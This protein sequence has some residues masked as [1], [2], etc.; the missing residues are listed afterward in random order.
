MSQAPVLIG[1][2]SAEPDHT[3][4]LTIPDGLK[5]KPTLAVPEPLDAPDGPAPLDEAAAALIARCE[6]E[7]T[8]NPP[9]TRAAR[10][11]YEIARLHEHPLNDARTASLHYQQAFDRVPDHTPTIQGL[12]R[13]LIARRAVKQALPL[14][15]AE[16]RLTSDP[17]AK[18][19]LWLAKG[20]VLED[21]LGLRSDALT[22]YRAGLD[23]DPSDPALLEA[24]EQAEL[25]SDDWADLSQTYEKQANV[26]EGDPP[27][28]SALLIRRAQLLESKLQ[29]AEGAVAL[30][31][32]ALELAPSASDALEALKRL[33]Y[34]KGRFRDLVGALE[35]EAARTDSASV[36]TTALYTIARVQAEKLGNRPDAIAALERAIEGAPFDRL[37]LSELAQLRDASRDY[38]GLSEV[39]AQL[40]EALSEDEEQAG[41]FHRIGQIHDEHLADPGAAQ[42]WFE[43]ALRIDPCYVP[44]LQ[45]LGNLYAAAGAHEALLAMHLAEAE[46]S[47]DPS[48]RAAAHA[49][50]A[51][52]YETKLGHID[53]AI[54]HHARALSAVPIYAPSFKALTRLFAAQGRHGE[55]IELYERAVERAESERAISYLLK[56]GALYEDQLRDPVQAIHAYRRVIERDMRHL[57]A[58]HALSRVTEAAGRFGELVEALVMEAELSTDK[59]HKVALLHRAGEVLDQ[60]INDREGAVALLKRVI[61]ID[62]RY[63]PA[64]TSLGR[65]YYRAGR[66]EDLLAMYQAELAVLGEDPRAVSLVLKMAELSEQRLGR[67]GEATELYR[68]AVLLDPSST[69]A[70]HAYTRKLRELGKWEDLL[71]L[72]AKEAKGAATPRERASCFFQMGEVLEYRLSRLDAALD[73]YEK[74]LGEAPSHRPAREAQIRLRSLRGDH[75]RL[76]DELLRE[77]STT[78]ET[79]LRV[80]LF[81]RAGEILRDQLRDLR[82]AIGCFEQVRDAQPTHLGTLIALD[83]LYRKTGQW[84][85][86]SSVLAAEAR[87]FGDVDTRAAALRELVRVASRGEPDRAALRDAYEAILDLVPNDLDALSGLEALALSMSDTALLLRV[88]ERFAQMAH[89]RAVRAAHLTR[90]GELLEAEEPQRAVEAYRAAL[91]VDPENLASTRGLSRLSERIDSPEVLAE[92]ARRESEVLHDR[93]TSSRL[94]VRAALARRAIRGE[95]R[96]V[97]ADLERALELDPDSE[98]AAY[99]LSETLLEVG[100]AQRLSDLLARAAGTASRARGAALWREVARLHA[101]ALNNV[102][103]AI[104]ALNRALRHAPDDVVLLWELANLFRRDG[105]WNEAANLLA[106]VVQISKA[107]GVLRD[108]HIELAAIH[109]E[110][111][112]DAESALTH[113]QQAL[114]LEP[115]NPAALERY[116]DV[117]SREKKHAEAATVAQRLVDVSRMPGARVSALL[118][119]ARIEQ[120]R[121]DRAGVSRALSEA[122]AIDGPSGGAGAAFRGAIGTETTYAD[123]AA[124]LRKHIQGLRGNIGAP[125][126]VYL[127]LAKVQAMELSSPAEGLA[128]LRE[129]L[130]KGPNNLNLRI[131]HARQLRAVGALEETA[132]EL[133]LLLVLDVERTQTWQDLAE[134]FAVMGRPDAEWRVSQALSLLG[135]IE[136]ERGQPQLAHVRAAAFAGSVLNELSYDLPP[137]DA[138]GELLVQLGEGLSK[139][140]PADLEG[141]G[142]SSRDKLTPRSGHPFRNLAERI[143]EIV[144]AGEFDLYVHRARNRGIGVELGDT[145]SLLFPGWLLEAPE[146]HQVFALAR[147]L[148][149]VARSCHAILKLTPREL[150][151]VLAA[152]ARTMVA[153]FGRGLTSEDLL[154]DQGRRIYKALSRRARKAAEEVVQRYVTTA[155]IEFVSWCDGRDRLA[156]RAAALLCDDLAAAVEGVLRSRSDAQP[157]NITIDLG[158]DSVRDLMRF[159]VSEPALRARTRAGIG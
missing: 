38:R 157:R 86:L 60:Q 65:I 34:A 35:I 48:R 113:L 52:L 75:A 16:A 7:L 151:V 97:A 32:T 114:K 118:H 101:D 92:A 102:A 29:D 66:W 96:Q 104:S 69:T 81:M 13:T 67:H 21:G 64:L 155:P 124:A 50:V 94:W 37:L 142:V 156:T 77:A 146:S 83:A 82:R 25:A 58:I 33:Y 80:S 145:P 120:R 74:A 24:M 143:A 31:E 153:G 56:I 105:Q 61:A 43:R 110:R 51:E 99:H 103:G 72:L 140:Y 28:R 126:E 152:Y 17:R 154:E 49:R 26:L 133:R 45:A 109:D 79:S 148:S 129:A 8:T 71:D 95:P 55:L 6:E 44:A 130:T 27:Q 57:G 123:Y 150:E 100:D 88:D 139:L 111:L 73:V 116:S 127:E 1:S 85:E 134:C 30:Y 18:A 62:P 108:A 53:N 122:V 22:A 41:L 138:A 147:V 89:D 91:D 54:E 10:L 135:A 149:L 112:G 42:G 136:A 131:E 84:D 144:G 107:P 4:R 87:Y 23:L 9:A 20:R 98:R 63:V 70:K 93:R 76:V 47:P 39:L 46:A 19:R 137:F 115:D 125:A 159:W 141:Y 15:E 14:F 3:E 11:H 117:L 36:R 132:N 59:A 158:E 90:M 68:R 5:L 119:L 40:T 128:T 12:R 78:G 106:R 2:R 121:G